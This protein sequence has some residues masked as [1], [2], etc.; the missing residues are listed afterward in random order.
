MEYIKKDGAYILRLDKGEEVSTQLF[1]F[2]KREGL[3]A[4]VVTGLGAADK[5]VIGLFDPQSKVYHRREF[6][7]PMEITSLLGNISVM[8]GKPYLHLHINLCNEELQVIGGHMSEC[9][10]SATCEITVLSLDMEPGRK[11]STD[12]GLNL[13]Q[14]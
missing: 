5:A 4:G 8:D 6:T 12:I 10:I 3:K 2:C 9:W 11:F 7:G 13:Y 14:F 1:Q